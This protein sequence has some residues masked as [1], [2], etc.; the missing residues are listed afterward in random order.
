VL[1]AQVL[2]RRGEPDRALAELDAALADSANEPGLLFPRRQALAH[3]AGTLLELGRTD[4]ALAAAQEAVV[5]PAEDVRSEV[6]ALRVL[7]TALRAAGDPDGGRKA[8]EQALEA[9]RSTGQ[10]AEVAPTEALLAAG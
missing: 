2:R 8:L 3:R 4:E 1:H 5:A 9:A 7:G 10:T 6:V